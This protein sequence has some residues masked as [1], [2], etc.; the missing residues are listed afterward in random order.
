MKLYET[1]SREKEVLL[2]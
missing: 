1:H 2:G